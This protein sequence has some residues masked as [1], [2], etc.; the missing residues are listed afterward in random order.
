MVSPAEGRL[1]ARLGFGQ[2]FPGRLGLAFA[3]ETAEVPR[4]YTSVDFDALTAGLRRLSKEKRRKPEGRET[5]RR[6]G[7]AA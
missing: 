3:E 5:V 2:E 6:S 1:L 4:H 7:A